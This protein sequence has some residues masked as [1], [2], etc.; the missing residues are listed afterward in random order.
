MTKLAT[1]LCG[2]AFLSCFALILITFLGV[3][4]QQI[5][6]MAQARMASAFRMTVAGKQYSCYVDRRVK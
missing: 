6:R 4:D 2:I 1:I 3:L 5:D